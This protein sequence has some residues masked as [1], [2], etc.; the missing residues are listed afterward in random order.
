[1]INK[2]EECK[3]GG[4]TVFQSKEFLNT[5]LSQAI[6]PGNKETIIFQKLALPDYRVLTFNLKFYAKIKG[7]LI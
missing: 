2:E 7:R 6:E 1:M 4:G 5:A 3:K